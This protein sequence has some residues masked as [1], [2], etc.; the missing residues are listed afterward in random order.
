M[1][2][3]AKASEFASDLPL[4]RTEFVRANLR[5]LNTDRALPIWMPGEARPRLI[6]RSGFEQDHIKTSQIASG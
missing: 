4:W 1:A 2:T 3:F 5:E 6:S